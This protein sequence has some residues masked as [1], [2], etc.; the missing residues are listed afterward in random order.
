[1]SH[2]TVTCSYHSL[3]SPTRSRALL[4]LSANNSKILAY[5]DEAALLCLINVN[6]KITGVNY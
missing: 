5:L 3:R 1:M 4:F 6:V 2:V